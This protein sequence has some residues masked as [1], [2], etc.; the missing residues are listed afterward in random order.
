MELDRKFLVS[1]SLLKTLAAQKQIAMCSLETANA[2]E[3]YLFE[4]GSASFWSPIYKPGYDGYDAETR[5]DWDTNYAPY[6]NRR[7]QQEVKIA[8][9]SASVTVQTQGT[10]LATVVR[11]AEVAYTTRTETEALSYTVTAGKTFYLT[12]FHGA[13]YA[14]LP[15][16]CRLKVAGS[17]KMMQLAG[18]NAQ[19]SGVLLYAEPIA[20]GGQVV[21]ATYEAQVAPSGARVFLSF[22]GFEV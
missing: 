9:T 19:G 21:S 16:I 5:N 10:Q 3:V 6:A 18:Q 7:V 17:T 15:T 20:T 4:D 8:S 11:A 1:W 14:P 13:C 12:R 2:T 22:A